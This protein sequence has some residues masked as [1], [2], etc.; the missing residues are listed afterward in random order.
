MPGAKVLLDHEHVRM[1]VGQVL[2]PFGICVELSNVKAAGHACSF[3]S[4][5]WVATISAPTRPTCPT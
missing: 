1:R 4:G 2:V 5:A 3:R